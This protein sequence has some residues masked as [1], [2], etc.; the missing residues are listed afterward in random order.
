MIWNLE[1]EDLVITGIT[2][3]RSSGPVIDCHR[4]FETDQLP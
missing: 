1:H 3:D 2:V 4:F